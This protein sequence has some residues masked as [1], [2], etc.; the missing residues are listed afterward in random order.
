MLEV[1]ENLASEIPEKPIIV[2][3]DGSELAALEAIRRGVRAYIPVTLESTVAMAAV[4]L[5]MLG[6]YFIPTPIL[7]GGHSTHGYDG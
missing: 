1:V 4:K 2:L 3:S 6:G 7:I 5:V